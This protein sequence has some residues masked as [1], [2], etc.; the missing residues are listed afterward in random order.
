MNRKIVVALA[1]ALLSSAASAQIGGI[2]P[3][4]FPRQVLVASL[5]AADGTQGLRI[6]L[7][8]SDCDANTA[9]DGVVLCLDTGAAWELVTGGGGGGTATDGDSAT[10]FFPAGELEHERGGLEADVSAFA[11]LLR[12]AAGSTSAVSTL[13]GLNTAL[14]SSIADGAHTVD[15]DTTCNDA[16]VNCLFAASATEGGAATTATALAANGANC[17]AGSYPLGVDASGAVEGCTVAAGGSTEYDPDDAPTSGLVSPS[18]EFIDTVPSCSW[19]NQQSAT[20]TASMDTAVLDLVAGHATEQMATC[21]LG[22]P[23]AGDWTVVAKIS[24]ATITGT[25]NLRFG[26]AG[27]IAGT[28]ATPSDLTVSDLVWLTSSKEW[29]HQAASFSTYAYGSGVSHGLTNLYETAITAVA[30][31]AACLR[32]Q[33]NDTANT[34]VYGYAWDCMSWADSG[35]RSSVA[36]APSNIGIFASSNTAA[37]RVP[38]VRVHWLR[39]F[40]SLTDEVGE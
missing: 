3:W 19:G 16:G 2:A 20:W 32:I 26:L 24:A 35:T 9:D 10:G 25:A 36:T 5:P 15:T 14:G 23:P 4:A 17:S 33:H 29:A 12:I 27:L 7:D 22:A 28:I 8:D 30:P 34:L 37:T 40:N 38:L 21:W 6:V 1:M 31:P 18:D 11:G 13:A 39:V